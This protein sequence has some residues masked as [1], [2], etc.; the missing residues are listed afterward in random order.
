MNFKVGDL[1]RSRVT[2]VTALVTAIGS[3]NERYCI[4]ED[5]RTFS[6]D[7]R[8]SDNWFLLEENPELADKIIARL[9]MAASS[10][11]KEIDN[12]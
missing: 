2:Y 4:S 9:R 8:Y 11:P 1:I 10:H 7:S 12:D 5:G 6:L 3:W